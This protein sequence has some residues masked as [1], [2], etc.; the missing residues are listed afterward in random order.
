[1]KNTVKYETINY[2]KSMAYNY[3]SSID[4]EPKCKIDD[5]DLIDFIDNK[6]F[7]DA[8]R[9]DLE[10][11]GFTNTETDEIINKTVDGTYTFEES[12]CYKWLAYL[13]VLYNDYDTTEEL[14]EII[15]D[16]DLSDIE[17]YIDEDFEEIVKARNN[18]DM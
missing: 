7:L 16:S 17:D 10:D 11:K 1:M 13:Y 14:I 15:K 12:V 18:I 8:V 5:I 9:T 3:L 2:F 4:I 6:A